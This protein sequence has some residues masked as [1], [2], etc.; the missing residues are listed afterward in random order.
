MVKIDLSRTIKPGMWVFPAY[1]APVVC[2]WTRHEVHG[3]RSNLL[4]LIEHTGTHVDSPAHFIEEGA[5]IDEVPLDRF[6]GRAVTVD[7][8]NLAANNKAFT[9]DEIEKSILEN[10]AAIDEAI[11]LLRTGWE[12][13][14]STDDYQRNP[15]LSKEAA[16]YIVRRKVKA[17]GIDA[18]SIDPGDSKDFPAHVTLLKEGVVIYENL[19]NL[20]SVGEAEFTFVGLPLGIEKGSASPVR[21]IA[22]LE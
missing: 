20:E 6:Y 1:I 8:H 12:E 21:A 18:P 22:V 10:R 3:F 11:V 14:W 9:V 13:K 7:L 4:V 2:E 15:G 17:V 16:E 5:F 19:R